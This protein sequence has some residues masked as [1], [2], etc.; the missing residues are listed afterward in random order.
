MFIKMT[1]VHS[2]RKVKYK[3]KGYAK[4]HMLHDAKYSYCSLQI[5]H[6]SKTPF[7]STVQEIR[8]NLLPRVKV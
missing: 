1:S 4:I 2:R 5:E 8:V 3:I 6:G 7:P